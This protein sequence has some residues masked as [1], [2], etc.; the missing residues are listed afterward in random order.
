VILRPPDERRNFLRGQHRQVAY[1]QEFILARFMGLDPREKIFLPA[2]PWTRL[3]KRFPLPKGWSVRSR[4]FSLLEFLLAFSLLGFSLLVAHRLC[5][6][7]ADAVVREISAVE[8]AFARARLLRFLEEDLVAVDPQGL[9]NSGPGN[10]RWEA[11]AGSRIYFWERP[12]RRLHRR[13]GE[14]NFSDRTVLLE[15][16]EEFTLRPEAGEWRVLLR[17]EGE[18]RPRWSSLPRVAVPNSLGKNP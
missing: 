13:L 11:E 5:F 14:G 18:I 4:G 12:A 15:G 17:L 3:A 1:L 9:Q 2:S 6:A 7:T 16:V 10:Y 8:N